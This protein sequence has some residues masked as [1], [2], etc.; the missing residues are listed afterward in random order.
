MQP[1]DWADHSA[2]FDAVVETRHGNFSVEMVC[3]IIDE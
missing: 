1:T 3:P 2:L